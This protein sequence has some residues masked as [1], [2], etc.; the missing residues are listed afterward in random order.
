MRSRSHRAT[1]STS[2][3][4]DSRSRVCAQGPMGSWQQGV[5]CWAVCC[6]WCSGSVGRCGIPGTPRTWCRSP[7]APWSSRAR[8]W[9]VKGKRTVSARVVRGS[10]SNARRYARRRLSTERPAEP[11]QSN[12]APGSEGSWPIAWGRSKG[13]GTGGQRQACAGEGGRANFCGLTCFTQRPSDHQ[14][15]NETLAHR[16][17][18]LSDDRGAGAVRGRRVTFARGVCVRVRAR[19]ACACARARARGE[20]L[21]SGPTAHTQGSSIGQVSGRSA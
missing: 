5:R 16:R 3:G 6:A 7:W 1:G 18:A 17:F 15:Q 8:R 20:T 14:D 12:R 9:P 13:W 10:A 4:V 2:P 21:W 11:L 19:K